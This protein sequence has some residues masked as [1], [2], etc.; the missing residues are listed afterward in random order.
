MTDN[1]SD[2]PNGVETGVGEPSM[3]DILASIRRIIAEDDSAS[4]DH[5]DV[6][7]IVN[8]DN[9]L[10]SAAAIIPAV[11]A[12]AVKK[13]SEA[14]NDDAANDDAAN[15]DVLILDQL[16]SE[17]E[18][19]SETLDIDTEDLTLASDPAEDFNP[20]SSVV[21]DLEDRL[22]TDRPETED[23]TVSTDS[24]DLEG[25]VFS[26]MDEVEDAK[27]ETIPLEEFNLDTEEEDVIDVLVEDVIPE[28]T[29]EETAELDPLAIDS[30]SDLDIVKSLMADLADTSFLDDEVETQ[31]G[32]MANDIE[33]AVEE[34]VSDDVVDI[35]IPPLEET[36]DLT[37]LDDALDLVI[38]EVDVPKADAVPAPEA[39]QDQ[40]LNDILELA[41]QDEEVSMDDLDLS[42]E[43]APVSD[44]DENL[45]LQIAAEAE[46]DA[47]DE[48]SDLAADLMDGIIGDD[49][50]TAEFTDSDVPSTEEILNELDLALAEVTQEDNQEIVELQDSDP[51][52]EPQEEL[53]I[54]PE[55]VATEE[56]KSDELIVEPQETEDMPSPARKNAIINEVTEEAA[57]GAFAEL[58][59][60]VEDQAVF[61]ESGPRI[62][63]IV[64]DALRPML[65]EWLDKNLKSI[66][67]R[68][69]TKEVKRISS[70]K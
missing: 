18:T 31:T 67:E 58:S 42:V 2:T 37:S 8:A 47:M 12:G 5:L 14:A 32:D 15:D 40:I 60:A 66:V 65:Q 36:E 6:D 69:V 34:A 57:S 3:E 11:T 16:V 53:Q 20:V 62:G 29:L 39:E 23:I 7:G 46:A 45:L 17:L 28:A 52:P 19:E 64:Q 22:A 10:E 54:E 55:I 41:I 70:G 38:P 9:G 27:A 63:D 59:Q 24:D 21:S 35:E 33:P 25:L 51:E 50:E 56:D 68:A 13:D 44:N 1:S 49:V 30:E 4:A 43:E 26:N 61:T 48:D